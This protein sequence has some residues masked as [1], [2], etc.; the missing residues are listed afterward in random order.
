MQKKP[1][2]RDDTELAPVPVTRLSSSPVSRTSNASSKLPQTIFLNP[3]TTL[4]SGDHDVFLNSTCF[5]LAAVFAVLSRSNILSLYTSY[6]ET[7]IAYSEFSS[8]GALRWSI[9]GREGTEATFGIVR[10]VDEVG[11][12]GY[13]KAAGSFKSWLFNLATLL[14]IL[15]KPENGLMVSLKGEVGALLRL[16][17]RSVLNPSRDLY[18]PHEGGAVG[19]GCASGCVL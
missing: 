3:V 9:L 13:I 16:G 15:P 6:I 12:L 19:K 2:L 5:L 18:E 17:D 4:R 8:I 7:T 14:V 11:M 1:W 10:F